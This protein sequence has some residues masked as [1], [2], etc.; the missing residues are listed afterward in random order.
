M[1]RFWLRK[2][3]AGFRVDAISRLFEDEQLRDIPLSNKPG[4]SPVDECY[5]VD[6]RYVANQPETVDMVIQWK[7]VLKEFEKQDGI[8]RYK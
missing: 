2:G 3:V 4:C 5:L 8:A 1:L 6:E 7:S